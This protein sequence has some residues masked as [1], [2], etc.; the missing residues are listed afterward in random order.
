MY[1][2]ELEEL[3]RAA[4]V[5]GVLT[6]KEREILKKRAAKEGIDPDE[7]DLFLDSKVQEIDIE[8]EQ[9]LLDQLKQENDHQGFEPKIAPVMQTGSRFKH[10]GK[11]NRTKEIIEEANEISEGIAPKGTEAEIS[12]GW[13]RYLVTILMFAFIV[14]G[15]IFAIDFVVPKKEVNPIEIIQNINKSPMLYTVEATAEILISKSGDEWYKLGNRHIIIPVTA[16]LKA[17]I[18]LRAIKEG[19]LQIDGNVVK[20]T[21]PDPIVEMESSKII[22]D[23]IIEVKDGFFRDDFSPEEKSE[24]AAQASDSIKRNLL[25]YDLIEPAQEQAKL[26]LRN[27]LNSLGYEL[28]CNVPKYDNEGIMKF[29]R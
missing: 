23:D 17:G 20:L 26:F 29:F 28:E 21:L 12:N 11:D 16:N 4:F 14:I 9:K 2:K 22:Y 3:I 7:F 1:S 27:M 25:R 13:L 10:Q 24:L 19:D 15:I 8:N 5:D 18:D 6:A